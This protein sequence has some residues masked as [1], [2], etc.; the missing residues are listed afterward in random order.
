MTGRAHRLQVAQRLDIDFGEPKQ[1]NDRPADRRLFPSLPDNVL[2]ADQGGW[3]SS[4]TLA[5]YR[6]VRPAIAT[7]TVKSD[8]RTLLYD[9]AVSPA[10]ERLYINLE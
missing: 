5:A 10:P 3:R 8:G 4:N 2:R 6:P 1:L 9:V 7:L